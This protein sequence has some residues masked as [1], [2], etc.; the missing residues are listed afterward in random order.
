MT[1]YINSPTP[2]KALLVQVACLYNLNIEPTRVNTHK[3]QTQMHP[4]LEV[5][6]VGE[7]SNITTKLFKGY[8]SGI[9]QLEPFIASTPLTLKLRYKKLVCLEL[10]QIIDSL[11]ERQGARLRKGRWAR[12]IPHSNSE[13]VLPDLTTGGRN[14]NF[15]CI[16][17]NQTITPQF[18]SE[19]LN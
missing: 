14:D 1:S 16:Y 8:I 6:A 13:S 19:N 11:D 2:I 15:K 17:P 10:L 7:E 18:E 9:C 3:A 5:K 12:N 4:V